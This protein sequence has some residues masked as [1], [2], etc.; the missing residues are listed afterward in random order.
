M[1]KTFPLKVEDLNLDLRNFRTIPQKNEE[2]ALDTMVSIAPVR[3][4][5]L[6]ESLLESG[7]LPTENII[8]LKTKTGEEVVKEGNRRIGALKLILGCLKLANHAVPN[9]ISESIKNISESWKKANSSVPCAI[10]DYTEESLVD[11]IVTLAHGKGEKA[12]RDNWTSVAK[13]RHNRDKNSANEY[14]LDLLEKYLKHGR[15]LT[16]T[17]KESWSGDYPLTVLDDVMGRIAS[18]VGLTSSKELAVQYPSVSFK[19]NIE[20]I[21]KDIGEERITFGTTRDKIMDFIA[22]YGIPLPASPKSTGG[23]SA[24][25]G[26]GIRLGRKG[27]KAVSAND[28]RSV[29]RALRNFH[30][31]GKGR[32]KIVTLLE[33][34]LSLRIDKH[35]HAFCFLLRAMFELSAKAY[36]SDNRISTKD[37]KKGSDKTLAD[38]LG[39]VTAHILHGKKASD[40][41]TKK[42]HG[43]TTQLKKKE[44]ILSVTSMNQ[45]I[46]NPDFMVDDAHICM[47]FTNIFPLLIEMNR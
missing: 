1:P 39:S 27:I 19:K 40:P 32:D 38:V 31:R 42:L 22:T 12:G 34:A 13:A 33:E 14:G 26:S 10:Y 43:A 36:C 6:C 37:K 30:P 4:W 46:H 28:P 47:V 15:N 21:L 17:E 45:L 3:F 5:A 24:K 2:A 9:G 7:Y 8:V 41:L 23:K 18:R 44:G 11:K 25:N 35:P 20:E 29:I 16:A